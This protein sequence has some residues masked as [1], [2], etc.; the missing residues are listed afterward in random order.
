M[1]TKKESKRAQQFICDI[2]H[3]STSRHTN[4]ERHILTLKHQKATKGNIQAAPLTCEFCNKGYKNRTGLWRHKQKCK[5]NVKNEP[6]SQDTSEMPDVSKMITPELVMTLLTQN[7]E[8]MMS[9]TEF[10]QLIV[11][12]QQTMVEQQ[13]KIIEQ[14]AD[15]QKIQTQ[16]LEVVKEGKTI[17]NTN[18]TNSNNKF[19]LNFFLNEQCKDAMNIADFVN[20]MVLTVEDLKKTGE[21]G[22]IDGITKIFTDKLREMDTY[23]R[24]MHCTD[25]KRETL[26]IKNSD[27]WAKD[28]EDKDKIKRAIECI[29]NKNL[30]NLDTWKEE[31]PGHE[32][33]DSKQ[34]KELVQIMTNSLGGMGSQ[35]EKNKQKIIKNVL[36]EVIVDR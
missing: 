22:Y 15:N 14:Q 16:L 33:M 13:N 9:N 21:L 3:F 30:N 19:N 4:W 5:G 36:K 1:A 32:V 18:T 8:L 6:S 24:P 20:N 29:A 25:L 35:R 7:Q 23:N 10:K 11:E 12:Q 26:Y 17:N 31:N 27:E 2:C 28:T 34:D